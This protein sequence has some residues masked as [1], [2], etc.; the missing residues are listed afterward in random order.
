MELTSSAMDAHARIPRRHVR[1]GGDVSPPLHWQAVPEEAVELALLCE[2]PDAPGD[3]PFVHWLLYGIPADAPGL[4]EGSAR[5][6]AGRNDWGENGYGGP[7]PPPGHG[8]HHYHFRLY[9]L[10][11]PLDLEPGASKDELRAAMRGKVV[12]EAEFVGT[13][14][15]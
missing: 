11:A 2:D 8:V 13:Y 4:D 7:Q 9:A 10:D 5:G 3:E 6:S 15:R 14:E 12:G 1:D